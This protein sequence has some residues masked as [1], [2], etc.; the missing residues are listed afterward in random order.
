DRFMQHRNP[1]TLAH[2]SIPLC[3]E[4]LED[5]RLLSGDLTSPPLPDESGQSLIEATDKSSPSNLPDA[6]P[7][8][9]DAQADTVETVQIGIVTDDGEPDVEVNPSELP[10]EIT[11]AIGNRFPGAQLVEAEQTMAGDRAVF[12][13]K[14]QWGARLIDL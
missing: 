2:R 1:V 9:P 7:N 12:E 11:A 13:V 3:V 8:V 10:A 4:P 5:R 6:A 14:T